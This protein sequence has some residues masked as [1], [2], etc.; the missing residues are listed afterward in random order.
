MKKEVATKA[1]ASEQTESSTA[2]SIMKPV[3]KKGL[4]S[5]LP[6]ISQ[7]RKVLK[8]AA[9][10]EPN[11]RYLPISRNSRAAWDNM[12]KAREL[13]PLSCTWPQAQSSG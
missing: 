10:K 11:I 5:K 13:W 12:R 8:A 7:G 4:D 6:N 3:A 9:N 2:R 1:S